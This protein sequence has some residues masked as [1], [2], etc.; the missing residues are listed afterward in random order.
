VS[1]RHERAEN[2]KKP[3]VKAGLL[4]ENARYNLWNISDFLECDLNL[5]SSNADW[6]G[7]PVCEVCWPIYGQLKGRAGRQLLAS[8]HRS[9]MGNQN[10][11]VPVHA[12]TSFGVSAFMAAPTSIN[13]DDY[14]LADIDGTGTGADLSHVLHDIQRAHDHS[15]PSNPG[16][17]D[18]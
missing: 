14:A 5:A 13:A 7:L 4:R 15:F 10:R 11:C 17:F 2:T 3:S 18:V 16:G 9:T 6:L 12:P 1:H 8:Y